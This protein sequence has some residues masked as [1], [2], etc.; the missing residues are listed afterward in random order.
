MTAGEIDELRIFIA[1]LLLGG[2]RSLAAGAGV[3]S[4]DDAEHALVVEAERC[5]DDVLLKARLREW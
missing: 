1:P 4:V 3:Q 2:G 5:G